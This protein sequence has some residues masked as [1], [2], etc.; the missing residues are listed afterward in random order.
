PATIEELRGKLTAEELRKAAE[1][2]LE[3]ATTFYNSLAERGEETVE[4][5]RQQP[6][7]A[8]GL[9]RA[10]K[11]YNDAV[12]L[13]ED[14]LGVVSEQT[15]AVGEQAAK[16]AGLV[17]VKAGEAS[18]AVVE[19]ADGLGTVI[20]GA[21]LDAAQVIEGAGDAVAEAGAAADKVAKK[22]PAKKTAAKKAPA[23][24]AVAQ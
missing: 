13:T 7:V 4:R 23:K 16:L 14:A 18:D 6:L 5:L 22:A 1:P 11:T 2:Y 12:D 15:R 21:A 17:G 10:E 9:T 3:L 24:K 20:E 8:E 19:A